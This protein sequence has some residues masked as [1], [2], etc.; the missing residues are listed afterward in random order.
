MVTWFLT[1]FR[2]S[3]I[4]VVTNPSGIDC[5][6]R[7][8]NEAVEYFMEDGKLKAVPVIHEGASKIVKATK[9]QD[10]A[11]IRKDFKQFLSDVAK[12]L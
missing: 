9:D 1:T 3:G 6:V 4:D 2:S 10:F 5:W 7:G 11:A 8:I 12:N